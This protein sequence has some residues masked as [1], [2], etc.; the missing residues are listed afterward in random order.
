MDAGDADVLLLSRLDRLSRSLPVSGEVLER[1]EA[2]GWAV[3]ALD[4]GMDMTTPGR[5][6][7]GWE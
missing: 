4:I 6:T 1:A 3:Q 5:R 7:D 2:S